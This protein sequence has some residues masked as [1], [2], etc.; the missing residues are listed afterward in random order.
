MEVVQNITGSGL[1][2][3]P[4]RLGTDELTKIA[5]ALS[6]KTR[7]NILLELNI[8]HL[9]VSQIAGKLGQT[10]ANISAQI[11]ILHKAGLVACDYRPGGHGV[12]KVCSLAR[13]KLDILLS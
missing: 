9:D 6:S 13:E 2:T 12:R 10:E 7:Q 1:E 3:P 11:A 8:A 4:F 5:K